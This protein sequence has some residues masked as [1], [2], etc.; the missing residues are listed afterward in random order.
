MMKTI[1]TILAL[2][3][4]LAQA[5]TTTPTADSLEVR[6]RN[7]ANNGTLTYYVVPDGITDQVVTFNGST[8]KPEYSKLGTGLSRSGNVLTLAPVASQISDSTSIGRTILTS[9]DAAAVRT[10]I[11]AAEP[12]PARSFADPT[13]NLKTCF[14]VSSTR[15]AMV[16]YGVVIG[17][18][19]TLASGQ[20]GTV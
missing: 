2:A 5:Q 18:T 8:T 19:A 1:F 14:H 9:A 4:G 16:V 3:A 12:S 15:V 11:G 17:R 13:R 7:S 10:A 20:V 6:Q